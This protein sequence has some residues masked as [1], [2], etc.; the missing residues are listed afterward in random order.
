[1]NVNNSVQNIN[2]K[3]ASN[4]FKVD[5]LYVNNNS[6]NV[7]LQDVLSQTTKNQ[8]IQNSSSDIEL[9]DY[10]YTFEELMKIAK[11]RQDE[12]KNKQAE[13]ER[14]KTEKELEELYEARDDN[15]GLFHPNKEADIEKKIAKLEKELGVPHKPDGM[16]KFS[17]WCG[18]AA[19]TAVTFT[20]SVA[21]GIVDVGET[22]IDGAV[23]VGGGA[24][25]YVVKA[26][27]EDAGKA[28]QEGIQDFVSYDASA[29]MYDAFVDVTGIDEDI[30]YGAAHTA[31][32]IVGQVAGYAAISMIPG[33]AA[34]AAGAGALAAAGAA[35]ESS[36]ANGATFDEAMV[37]STSAAVIGAVTGGAA[38]KLGVAAQGATSLG[39]VAGYTAAGAAVGTAE[40]LL[41]S[42]VE[43]LTYGNNDGT[44]YWDYM[45]KSGG[46]GKVAMGAAAGGLSVGVQSYKGYNEASST[47]DVKTTSGEPPTAAT[48]YAISQTNSVVDYNFDKIGYTDYV[49][50]L[51]NK[52]YSD[53]Q[54]VDMLADYGNRCTEISNKLAHADFTYEY[55]LKRGYSPQDAATMMQNTYENILNGRGMST[56][57]VDN[58]GIKYNI[59][60][61]FNQTNQAYDIN[62]INQQIQ[63]LPK[64][65]RESIT[66][67]NIY[68]TFNPADYY[69]N[70][71][72]NSTGGYFRSAA[73]GGN[74]Q[75]NLW[76]NSSVNPSTISHEAGHCFD[77]NRSYSESQEYLSAIY[78]DKIYSGMDSVTE[79]GKN[80]SCED[81][82]ESIAAY[83]GKQ[84]G[85][86][87]NK[88]PNRKAYFDKIF[89]NT[90]FSLNT[91]SINNLNQ[92]TNT[93]TKKYGA[94]N[95]TKIYYEYLTTGDL[96]KITRTDGARDIIKNMN[97]DEVLQYYNILNGGK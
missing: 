21:E 22:I 96:T 57:Y 49:C 6:T 91:Q 19:A 95:V 59:V 20:A 33:G 51:L 3:S 48:P 26:I 61:N 73:T 79:Y 40:P 9:I 18:D 24:I 30:A 35:A 17:D 50:D 90:N 97:M 36:Y 64:N 4:S 82:A 45:E 87:I 39:Q 29:E 8:T 1:M 27:D 2:L 80:N 54:I 83:F 76:A 25:S 70:N 63:D 78:N 84:N 94:S 44:S 71:T 68:D 7:V 16:E 28:M 43:Y 47:I 13:E 55:L 81:F 72:Y 5:K 37:V 42:G 67:I 23:Q 31:G 11:Q 15:N 77:I 14:K 85:V 86:D 32:N 66:E 89:N 75:I 53:T 38:N 60:N 93:L 34:V 56:I 10:E 58:N 65:V 46:W 88:F 69:W 12:Y 41:N 62:Y 74:G 52:G 92:V